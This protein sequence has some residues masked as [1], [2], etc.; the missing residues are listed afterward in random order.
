MG[1]TFREEISDEI[2]HLSNVHLLTISRV[3][4]L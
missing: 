4:I 1:N 2:E 3:V